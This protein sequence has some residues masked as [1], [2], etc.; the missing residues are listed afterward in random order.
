MKFKPIA[1]VAI[2]I[3]L[4]STI[5]LTLTRPSTSN[6]GI[7]ACTNK[8]TGKTRLTISGKCN[9]KSESQSPVTDLWGFQPTSPTSTQPKALKKHV[10]DANG[11]DLG[12]L[13]TQ[14]GLNL[15]WPMYK[16]GL[17]SLDNSGRA[18]GTI[19][20]WDPPIFEDKKC[21]LPYIGF[22]TDEIEQKTRAVVHIMSIGSPTADPQLRAFGVNGD[23]IAL[24]SS[25]F[26]M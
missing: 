4:G 24:P 26:F 9:I 25:V 20:S 18:G 12:E 7:L 23:L 8:S 15:F 22:P 11:Q 6:S 17:F 16:G 19:Y 21:R 2:G 3:L 13:V 10:V 5:T 14:E 1:L